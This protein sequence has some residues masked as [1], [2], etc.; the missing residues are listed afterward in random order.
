M[1][2]FFTMIA[3]LG[4]TAGAGVWLVSAPAHAQRLLQEGFLGTSPARRPRPVTDAV[5]RCSGLVLI[6]WAAFLTIA[7]LHLGHALF[8]G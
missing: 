1:P 7:V 6:G 2:Y 4:G 3:L 5:I 8:K